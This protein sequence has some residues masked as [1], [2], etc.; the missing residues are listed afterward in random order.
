M[1]KHTVILVTL[2]GVAGCASTG[3]SAGDAPE[4]ETGTRDTQIGLARGSVFDT[5]VPPALTEN[6]SEPAD[7]PLVK[8]PYEGFPTPIPHGVREL[9]PITW[10]DNACAGC[11][12]DSEIKVAGEATPVPKSHY[13]DLRRKP[14]QA[15]E[16][17]AGARFACM[18]C[19][20]V[21]TGAKPLVSNVR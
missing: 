12:T 10:K 7:Y 18:A 21:A 2:L 3:S 5:Y 4:V 14:D 13:V 16:D 15:G 1:L 20:Q 6:D 8:P 9:L 17:V 19:H 11:H